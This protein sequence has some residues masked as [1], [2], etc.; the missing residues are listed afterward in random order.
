MSLISALKKIPV[1][2][3][4]GN[5][6]FETK[7]KVI[8]LDNVPKDGCGKRILD[9]G[10]REGVQSRYFESLGYQV[11]SIDVEKVYEN[12]KVVDCNKSLPFADSEF[13]VVW[14]AEVIEHLIDPVFS[15][16]EAR[17]VLKPGGRL[18]FTTP[19]SFP[20]YFCVL[21]MVGLTPQVIQRKDHI[22]FFDLSTI[23]RLFPT[24]KL[25]GFLPFT[26]CRPKIES[27]I[28]LLSPTFVIVENKHVD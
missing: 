8:A 2:V 10:C 25:Y 1:D 28:G 4:Q 22:H 19:N 9:I 12:A 6:R 3:G 14:S 15:L 18:V 17:R 7:G 5:L 11:T 13:D 21:A 20:F 16:E 23:K 26:F 24:A 27:M